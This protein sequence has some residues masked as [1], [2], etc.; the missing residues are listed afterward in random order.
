M[1]SSSLST[2]LVFFVVILAVAH[3][4]PLSRRD[5]SI[6]RSALFSEST[7][8]FVTISETGVHANGDA[9]T[10]FFI[11]HGPRILYSTAMIQYTVKRMC[12]SSKCLT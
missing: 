5:I 12:L 3:A 1:N 9:G 6:P 10:P 11:M 7:Y 4:A 8:R 2:F